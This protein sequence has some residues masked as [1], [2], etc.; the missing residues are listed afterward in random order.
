LPASNFQSADNKAFYFFCGFVGLTTPLIIRKK[1]SI[2]AE[3]FLQMF[4]KTHS[5]INPQ[6]GR[7]SIYYRL[8]ENSRNAVGN[9]YQR[10]IMPVGFMDDVSTEELHLIA[11]T[12]NDR[13]SGQFRLIEDLPKVTD[14]VEHLYTRLVKEKR[15]DRVLD[16]RRKEADGD[17]QRINLNSVENRNVR[18]LG[19]EW[20]CLQTLRRL[21]IDQFLKNMN[22]SDA[23]RDLALAHIVC[24]TV[25]PASE[26]KTVRYMQEN[27]SI[28][29]LPGL[30]P[31]SITKD[32]LY[33]ISHRLYAEKDGLENHLSRRTNELFDLQDKIILYDLTNTYFEGEM[34]D[35][36]LARRGRS[37]EKRSDC[38]LLV[39]ALV[40]NVEGFL[41]YSAIYEG[42]MADCKTLGAMVDK[43]ASA[44]TTT[45]V[46]GEKD[47]RI[48]VIDAGIA[49]EDN[50]K[51]IT[52]KGY[53]YVCVSRSSLKKYMV[54]EGITPVVV[55][56]KKKGC[57]I[58]LV[59]V[60]AEGATDSEYYLKVTSGSKALK[61]TSMYSQFCTR[62]EEGLRLIVKGVVTKGGVKKYDKVHQR[63]GRLAQKY[64]S[65]HH[66]YE[67][68][69]EKDKKDVCTSI[70]WTKK[71]Q[72]TADKENT[73][74]VYF[75]KSSINE[76]NEN[77]VWTVYNCIREI[78]ATIRTLKSD[79]DLRPI[80]H[81]TDDASLA[82]LHLGL[83]AYW[84][85]NTIRH[86][87]K[88]E[89]ITSD[90]RELVR[91]MN[92]QKCVTTIMTNDKDQQ[93]S[94]RC[95]SKP[96]TK[97]AMIYEKLKLKPA[98]F[99]RKKSVV[100]KIEPETVRNFDWLKDTS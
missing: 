57:P 19:A 40:V 98:P 45:P 27:S 23:D 60:Q 81:K 13:I 15:I 69:I 52:G 44:T 25:Y 92:T 79:L 64:P 97:A 31:G 42:N 47:R 78:E 84:V 61:E 88:S 7:L 48:V 36:E 24:R 67:T 56:D 68:H 90:W 95:C 1:A 51:T 94:I 72:A 43:L 73:Y 37:K 58:E 35:S 86:Q 85:V 99:I 49:T 54:A 8:V 22:W 62:Y 38:P 65:V 71:E 16:V 82:H 46:I 75:L 76:A 80:F 3:I 9:V 41:K 83:M 70:I 34:R 66:L 77:L 53:D 87:L 17:W 21:Q 28:C 6:T 74:G 4:F 59:Q 39:L 2:F 50:L 63:I 55:Y 96:E 100:L 26:L 14:Y 20:L 12:L 32:R 11:D 18:E 91:V 10:S 29:E 33:R 5:R 30:D 89:G 93:I